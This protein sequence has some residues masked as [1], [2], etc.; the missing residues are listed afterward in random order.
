MWF[1]AL[2]NR[3]RRIRSLR[4]SLTAW[5]LGSVRPDWA[6]W[7][8][9]VN[10][11]KQK[12]KNRRMMRSHPCRNLREPGG[13][14]LK[15]YDS[16]LKLH[17]PYVGTVNVFNSNSEMTVPRDWGGQ[18][19]GRTGEIVTPGSKYQWDISEEGIQEGE[20]AMWWLCPQPKAVR[21]QA[22]EDRFQSSHKNTLISV[23]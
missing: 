22:A 10:K 4:S 8:P 21:L 5:D 3:G 23:I 18:G 15:W 11:Q 7:D 17:E 9:C 20:R 1:L 14:Y 6:M 12:T 13:H 19:W 16:V 2:G